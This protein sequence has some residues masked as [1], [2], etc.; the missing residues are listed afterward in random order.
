MWTRWK[1][2]I[3]NYCYLT[4]YIDVNVLKSYFKKM[5]VALRW[6]ETTSTLHSDC[7]ASWVPSFK[8]SIPFWWGKV[9]NSDW[10]VLF[11]R[12]LLISVVAYF[13]QYDLHLLFA[14]LLLSPLSSPSIIWW[15][16]GN[17]NVILAQR[18]CQM[19]RDSFS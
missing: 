7:L 19:V 8:S 13:G 12:I 6:H 16:K 11:L 17:W 3:S 5:Y 1:Y 15:Q 9:I 14:F 18:T 4:S 2:S 10:N